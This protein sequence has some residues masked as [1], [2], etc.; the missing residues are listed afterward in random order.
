VIRFRHIALFVVLCLTAT[1]AQGHDL[2]RTQVSIAFLADGS[3]ILDVANDP[4]WLLLRLERFSPEPQRP[5]MDRDERLRHLAP[6]FIDRVVLFVDGHEVR[7]DSAEYIPPR[8]Q[9][10]SDN[11]IPLATYRLRGRM[12]P[13]A[14]VLRWCYGLVIDPYP[15]TIRGADGHTKTEWVLGD[16]WSGTLDLT[17]R[18]RAPSPIG[19]YVYVL[20]IIGLL[21]I[22]FWL[23]P[24]P[25]R[26]R[27]PN[28]VG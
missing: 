4:N 11:L 10:P 8:P 15:L 22:A 19:V 2:E 27:H 5:G 21:L 12:S 9:L 18:F 24:G 6:I 14:R 20:L 3:F 7:P 16:A 26:P 25:M 1:A 28:P 13:S 17:T 23:R